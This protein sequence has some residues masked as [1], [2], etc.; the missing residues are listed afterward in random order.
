MSDYPTCREVGTFL[1]AYL[2]GELPPAE[3]RGFER[4]LAVCPSC[5]AYLRTYR[6]TLTLSR[7]A[8]GVAEPAPDAPPELVRAVL[9]LR[10][11][12]PAR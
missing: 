10:P 7:A 2:S 6:T 8:L 4:H 5:V 12:D 1:L 11:A 3:H 9:A